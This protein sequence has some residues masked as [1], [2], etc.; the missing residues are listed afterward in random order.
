MK[1]ILF[2]ILSVLLAPFAGLI[3][4]APQWSNPH[5][6]FLGIKNERKASAKGD[7]RPDISG[8]K[9]ERYFT[10]AISKNTEKWEG[11]FTL[12]PLP[13]GSLKFGAGYIKGVDTSKFTLLD[14]KIADK[15]TYFDLE[16]QPKNASGLFGSKKS[17]QSFEPFPISLSIKTNP[18]NG[19]ATVVLSPESIKEGYKIKFSELKEPVEKQVIG[20]WY[21]NKGF[22]SGDW[23]FEINKSHPFQ[24]NGTAKRE[25][26]EGTPCFYAIYGFPIPGPSMLILTGDS[27]QNPEACEHH[28]WKAKVDGEGLE[29]VDIH[30]TAQYSSWS[31]ER[32][33]E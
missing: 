1:Y 30:D 13:D 31:L 12:K 4:A 27:V 21:A 5:Q 3:F 23:T 28:G 24:V 26:L 16:T 29:F 7:K 11:L 18:E 25:N 15:T 32:K 10:M 8:A 17:F 22:S 6:Y 19:K 14:I 2:F 20:K 33:T 9:A